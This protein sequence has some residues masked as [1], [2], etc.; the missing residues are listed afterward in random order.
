[1]VLCE[2]V[3]IRGQPREIRNQWAD[4]RHFVLVDKDGR[5]GLSVRPDMTQPALPLVTSVVRR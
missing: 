5:G 2:A 4:T 3:D 1:V